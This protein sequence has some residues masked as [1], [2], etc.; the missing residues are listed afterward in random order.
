MA[1]T[2]AKG[3]E[4]LR[5]LRGSLIVEKQLGLTNWRYGLLASQKYVHNPFSTTPLKS[6][7]ETVVE[8]EGNKRTVSIFVS[9]DHVD[10]K[11]FSGS[12]GPVF[13]ILFDGSAP[14]AVRLA[15]DTGPDQSR[16]FNG[17]E[18]SKSF[19]SMWER[20]E[21]FTMPLQGFEGL[22]PTAPETYLI[23]TD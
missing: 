9:I 23:C 6:L 5:A 10:G 11:R 22:A 18:Y 19:M 14:N 15:M 4:Q 12:G 3:M 13:R 8:G 16:I 2:L 17:F 21:L 7:F 20:G 1:W